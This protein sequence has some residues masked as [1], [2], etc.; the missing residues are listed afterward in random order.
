MKFL[1]IN[2]I[3]CTDKRKKTVLSLKSS[4]CS[5]L[6]EARQVSA[7]DLGFLVATLSPSLRHIPTAST[8]LPKINCIALTPSSPPRDLQI[9]QCAHDLLMEVE[10]VGSHNAV[11][12]RLDIL[13]FSGESERLSREK[14]FI[15][16]CLCI[17]RTDNA[18]FTR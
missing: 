17:Y 3:V 11:S 6:I 9:T 15:T 10:V 12:L 4:N 18:I 14:T 1:C 13:T 7:E 5:T 2:V 8:H 16:Y